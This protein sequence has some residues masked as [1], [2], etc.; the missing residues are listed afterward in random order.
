MLLRLG[1]LLIEELEFNEETSI[2]D[3]PFPF[4]LARMRQ[5]RAGGAAEESSSYGKARGE[6]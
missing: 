2:H 5:G 3:S 6:R 1:N 4:V